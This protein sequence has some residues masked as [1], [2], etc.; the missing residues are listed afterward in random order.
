MNDDINR[1]LERRP[2]RCDEDTALARRVAREIADLRTK[3]GDALHYCATY[4]EPGGLFHTVQVVDQSG[5]TIDQT[6]LAA[7]PDTQSAGRATERVVAAFRAQYP[8][9]VIRVDIDGRAG[10]RV[11]VRDAAG[12]LL[13]EERIPS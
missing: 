2:A 3:H 5:A 9:G 13:A 10:V 8:A 6:W 1:D 11:T 4:A 7:L 12:E